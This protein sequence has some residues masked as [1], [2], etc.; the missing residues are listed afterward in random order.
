M[1][2]IY[3][4]DYDTSDKIWAINMNQIADGQYE[5]FYGRRG[6]RLTKRV[7]YANDPY[8]KITEKTRKGYHSVEGAIH[9]DPIRGLCY[10]KEKNHNQVELHQKHTK[11][12]PKKRPRKIV[13]LSRINTDNHSA[14][15]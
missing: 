6:S 9:I 4:Y 8:G 2:K 11:P 12:K 14:F 1:I 13:N 15:F 7:I 3:H 5:V 10:S